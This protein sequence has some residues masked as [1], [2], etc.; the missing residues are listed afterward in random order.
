MREWPREGGK[1]AN[2]VHVDM[3]K[4]AFWNGNRKGRRGNIGVDFWFL[5]KTLTGPLIVI[6]GHVEPDETGR[7]GASCVLDTKMDKGMHVVKKWFLEGKG[8]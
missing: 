3:G 8:N 1:G 5:R 6:G 7:N 2:N 4:T